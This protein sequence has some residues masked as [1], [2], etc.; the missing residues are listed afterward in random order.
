MTNYLVYHIASGHAFFTGVAAVILAAFLMR[1]SRNWL[2]RVAGVTAVCG[3]IGILLSSTPI[4]WWCYGVAMIA[5]CVWFVALFVKKWQTWA[6]YLLT[7]AWLLCCGMELP[8]HFMPSLAPAPSR[9]VTVIGDSVTAGTSGSREHTWPTLLT[10]EHRVKTQDLSHVADTTARA[11]KRA[12]AQ[13]LT[14]DVVLV[15]IGG[16]DLLGSTTVT[17]YRASLTSLLNGLLAPGRQIV[18]FELPLLPF[19]HRFGQVQREV[20]W[21]YGVQ[22]IPKRVFLG[23]LT[24]S[25]ATLDSIHLSEDGHRTMAAVIW[26]LLAPAMPPATG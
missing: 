22:L 13:P 19:Y 7:A 16:N 14:G 1:S 12:T 21:S 6:P 23:V 3:L 15:E 24:G 17:D 18:M 25:N 26:Q 9:R 8:Y 5:T 4:P 11:I 2:R 10:N 20:A